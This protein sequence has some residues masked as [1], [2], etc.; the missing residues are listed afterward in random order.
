MRADIPFEFR[1]GTTILPPGRYD[2]RPQVTATGVRSIRCFECK[3]GVMI[4][5]DGI[6]DRKTPATGK[7]VFNR[8]NKTYFLSS[9]WTPGYAQGRQLRKSK[10]ERELTRSGS[11]VSTLVVALAR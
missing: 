11:A 6:E 9:V 2:V 1:V 10:A 3:A 8:Y 7:L 5:T 4:L